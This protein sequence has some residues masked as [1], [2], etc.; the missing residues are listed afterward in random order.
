MTKVILE[1]DG[2]DSEY[3]LNLFMMTKKMYF[4]LDEIKD[5]LRSITNHGEYKGAYH[6]EL[7][8]KLD[9][10]IEDGLTYTMD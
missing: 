1:F 5:V 3:E 8:D 6:E 9:E 2:E 10:I 7:F 4:A